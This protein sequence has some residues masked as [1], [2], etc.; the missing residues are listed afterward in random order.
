V[1]AAAKSLG[2]TVQFVDEPTENAA[3]DQLRAGT[4]DLVIVDGQSLLVNQ[5]IG[6]GDTSTTVQLV[7]AAAQA[8]GVARAV[9]IAHLTPSQAS[10]LANAHPLPVQSLLAGPTKS[11]VNATS[12]IGLILIFLMLT[13]YNTWILMG[14]MEEKSSRVIEV[15]LAAVRPIQLLSGKVLGIGLVAFGQAALIVAFA[16]VLASIVGSGILHGSAPLVIVSTLVWLV[17]GYAFYCWVYAA[18]GSLVERQDQVQSLALP[19]SLP[20][21]FGYVMALTAAASGNASPFFKVLGYLPPTA[22][23]AMPVLVGLGEVAWWQFFISAAISVV[24]TV[25]V[26]RL[27][28]VIY[29]RAILRT[30]G[31]VK[32]RALLTR[33]GGNS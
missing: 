33:A 31:R 8:L 30:G 10:A 4:L 20:I 5:H 9:A 26:A 7:S 28:A 13:Q 15:L 3:R 18:G 23:F 12:L 1:T 14:V 11:K 2:T 16:L 19:L 21:I 29:R 27:A 17:L 6:A 24:C 32:L 22:P 25:G